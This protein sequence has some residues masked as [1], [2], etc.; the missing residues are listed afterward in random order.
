MNVC[1]CGYER[2][3]G[4]SVVGE[5]VGSADVLWVGFVCVCVYV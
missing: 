3:K 2:D 4:G 5:R 1:V